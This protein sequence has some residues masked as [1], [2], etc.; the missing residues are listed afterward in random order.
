MLTR[1]IIDEINSDKETKI[2]GIGSMITDVI[3]NHKGLYLDIEITNIFC[4]YVLRKQ[5]P[6]N[7]N[8]YIKYLESKDMEWQSWTEQK[9]QV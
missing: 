2:N 7:K 9:K 4:S 6:E 8:E 1:E 5:I 3:K